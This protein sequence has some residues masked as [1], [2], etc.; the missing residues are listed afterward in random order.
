MSVLGKARRT[1]NRVLRPLG[2]SV[3]P[4]GREEPES[5]GVVQPPQPSSAN[6]DPFGTIVHCLIPDELF[7]EHLRQWR[8]QASQKVVEDLEKLYFDGP[9]WLS[10]RR[11]LEPFEALLRSAALAK[12]F[13]LLDVGCAVGQLVPFLKEFQFSGLYVG[14]DVARGYVDSSQQRFGCGDGP[15]H[16]LQVD[17]CAMPFANASFDVVY[18]RST[19]ISTYHWQQA[20]RQHLR[21]ARKWLL[22]LQVPL[23]REDAETVFFLQHSRIHTSLLCS[24][25]RKAFLQQLPKNLKI[26]VK[27]SGSGFDVLNF[28]HVEWHDILIELL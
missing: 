17:A 10:Y 27:P 19:L 14:I 28:G 25:T 22:F 24:F 15:Y 16:F 13:C 26:D 21:V 23:H 5:S 9:G 3:I 2:V 8:K 1:L 7:T 4:L 12:D 6:H 11:S 20:V 18:S